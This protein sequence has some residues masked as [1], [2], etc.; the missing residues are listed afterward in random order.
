MNE[1]EEVLTS[2]GIVKSY[3]ADELSVFLLKLDEHGLEPELLEDEYYVFCPATGNLIAFF[4]EVP[5]L[6]PAGGWIN[7]RIHWAQQL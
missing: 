3:A 2:N 5:R 4:S 7:D 6:G 1:K